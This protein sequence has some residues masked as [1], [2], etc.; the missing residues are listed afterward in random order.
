MA[1]EM[2]NQSSSETENDDVFDTMFADDSTD[3][4][5]EENTEENTEETEETNEDENQ[6]TQSEEAKDF[7]NIR[8]NGEDKALTQDEAIMLAQKGMNYDKVKGKLDAL[9]NGALK[10]ISAIA[11]RAGMTIDEYAERLNDFQEQSEITQIANEYQKKH[12]DVDDDAAHEYANAV[13]QNKRDAKAR[14]DAESQAKRQ[15]QE[16]AYFR[17]QVQALYN[18]NPDIDIEHLDTEVIDDINGGMSPMEAYLRW[19][20]KSLRTKATNN[21]VNSK[22]K[23]NANSGLNSNNSSVGGD[24]FLEGLLGK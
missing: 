23:K 11:E 3:D 8:Y 13:Y 22:N 14:Q 18:Y 15:E 17:D 4:S 5:T 16:N 1:E 9:E 21:A 20:N 24:P 6:D 12:P 7:L 19:E 2:V 10:S